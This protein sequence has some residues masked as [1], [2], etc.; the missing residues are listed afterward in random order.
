M[1]VLRRERCRSLLPPQTKRPCSAHTAQEI[2]LRKRALK[3]QSTVPRSPSISS[4]HAQSR[5]SAAFCP[6]CCKH[7]L[8]DRFS[9][10]PPDALPTSSSRRECYSSS[11]C[12]C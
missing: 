7:G 8:A 4:L 6:V 12:R 3:T 10:F 5:R 2:L 9:C 1:L 11:P